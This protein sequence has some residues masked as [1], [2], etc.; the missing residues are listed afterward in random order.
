MVCPLKYEWYF[1]KKDFHGGQKY[2]GK[3]YAIVYGEVIQNGRTS[4]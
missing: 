1:P 3:N 2:V 4:D